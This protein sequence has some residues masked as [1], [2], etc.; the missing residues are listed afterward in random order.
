MK[1]RIKLF[2]SFSIIVV[3]G[4]LLGAVG[5][6]SNTKLTS[7]SQA[8]L[9][10]SEVRMSITEILNS[11]FLWREKLLDTVYTGAAFTGAL[12]SNACTLGKYLNGDEVKKMT[13][14]EAVLL[15]NQIVEPHRIIHS[16][17]GEIVN[18][19]KDD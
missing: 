18:H 10:L 16:K 19:L 17:A 14:P 6:Y 5:Y 3:I 4:V 15:L 12:D 7:S 13:D 2:G 8:I 1:I 9:R 11:H